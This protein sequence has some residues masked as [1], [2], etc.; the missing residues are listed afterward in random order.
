M[1]YIGSVIHIAAGKPATLDAAGVNAMSFDEIGEV[2]TGPQLGDTHEKITYKSIKSGRT[3]NS[4]GVAD[5]GDKSYTVA[6]VAGNA[7]MATVT[8]NNG[9]Q[10]DVTIRITLPDGRQFANVGP[11]ADLMENAIDA[12][13]YTGST[14]VQRVNEHL[15]M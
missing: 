6:H 2:I 1:N 11:I 14:F 4:N 12:T 5:G 8:A 3:V 10:S 9:K 7:G 15:T 13:S